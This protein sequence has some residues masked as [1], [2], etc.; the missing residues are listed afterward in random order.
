MQRKFSAL[1]YIIT[2][3][4]I[5]QSPWLCLK[6]DKTFIFRS[7]HT[8]RD[9]PPN[10]FYQLINHLINLYYTYLMYY[11]AEKNK[12][13]AWTAEYPRLRSALRTR[14][15]MDFAIA[16]LT[17]PLT[18][19]A[20]LLVDGAVNCRQLDADSSLLHL[21]G[22]GGEGFVTVTTPGGVENDQHTRI[23]RHNPADNMLRNFSLVFV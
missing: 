14:F 5:S 2:E 16:C 19:S 6:T 3:M 12:T 17:C 23:V 21:G 1:F 7:P 20:Q 18:T 4:F 13:M 15:L 10:S 11:N 8:A 22:G 9:T